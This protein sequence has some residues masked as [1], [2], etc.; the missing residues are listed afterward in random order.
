MDASL[1]EQR[2]ARRQVF[3]LL[4]QDLANPAYARLVHIRRRRIQVAAVVGDQLRLHGAKEHG[5]KLV[6][7][8]GLFECLEDGRRP[9]PQ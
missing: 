2:E 3:L 5:E 4:A 7:I 9:L 1:G 8:V 6:R